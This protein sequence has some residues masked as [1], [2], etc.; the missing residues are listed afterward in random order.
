MT[1]K[2]LRYRCSVKGKL[3]AGEHSEITRI[4]REGGVLPE[5]SGSQDSLTHRGER[6]VIVDLIK[7]GRIEIV[8]GIG[9]VRQLRFA[10]NSNHREERETKQGVDS[11]G[12]THGSLDSERDVCKQEGR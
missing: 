1:N 12:S 8:T 3:T 6:G 11:V 10:V 9:A 2:K 4:L 7:C 5:H